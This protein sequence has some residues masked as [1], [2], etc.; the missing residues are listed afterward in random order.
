[1]FDPG[2]HSNFHILFHSNWFA[3]TEGDDDSPLCLVACHSRFSP[4]CDTSIL[5]RRP[6]L[7]HSAMQE[8]PPYYYGNDFITAGC[9]ETSRYSRRP[10]AHANRI[11]R[12]TTCSTRTR[13]H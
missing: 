12:R 5:P 7:R 11:E 9:H 3:F 4:K 10:R 1:M 8:N 13:T 6:L 2:G